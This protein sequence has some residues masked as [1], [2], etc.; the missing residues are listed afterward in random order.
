MAEQ[1]NTV[2]TEKTEKVEVR[3]LEASLRRKRGQIVAVDEKTARRLVK[4]GHAERVK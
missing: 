3:Y 2:K 4:D 1:K